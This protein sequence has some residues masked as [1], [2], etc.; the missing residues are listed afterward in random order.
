MH[1]RPQYLTTDLPVAGFTAPE[2]F[3][4]VKAGV[5]YSAMPSWPADNRDDEIWHLVAFL[6]AMPTMSA[7]TFQNLAVVQPKVSDNAT[8]FGAPP[9]LRRYALRNDDEPPVT[10]YNYRSPVYGFSGYALGG[11]ITATCARCHGAD[12]AVGASSPI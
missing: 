9:M 2:L 12:G 8:P 11:N 1:P 10:S 4:I 3:R 7:G 5:K 6:R